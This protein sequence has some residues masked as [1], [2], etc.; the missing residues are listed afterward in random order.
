M[1]SAQPL[2]DWVNPFPQEAQTDCVNLAT[3][4]RVA[5]EFLISRTDPDHG[6]RQPPVKTW[7][8]LSEEMQ[9]SY[10][11]TMRA[12][13]LRDGWIT[14]NGSTYEKTPTVTDLLSSIL[15]ETAVRG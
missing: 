14:R 11:H 5:Y 9:E 10:E 15:G 7:Q 4:T 12:C 3:I 8:Q 1:S 6:T 13:L 2:N